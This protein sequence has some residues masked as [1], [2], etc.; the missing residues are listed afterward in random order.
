MTE[1]KTQTLKPS[2]GAPVRFTGRIIAETTWDTK[3]DCWMR[4][5]VW[6]TKGG[7]YIARIDGNIPRKPDEKHCKVGVVEPIYKRSKVPSYYVAIA[8]GGGFGGGGGS[9]RTDAPKAV[10]ADSSIIAQSGGGGG[11]ASVERKPE[12][13]D[14]AMQIAVLDFF[15]WHDRAKS[16]LKRELGWAPVIEVV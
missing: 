6:E 1:F 8:H 7:A 11:C 3:D 13:D 10:P 15:D 12:R 2:M 16:M 9:G 14:I 4:F 5:T